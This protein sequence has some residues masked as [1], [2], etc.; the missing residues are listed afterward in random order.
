MTLLEKQ[1]ALTQTFIKE[2]GELTEDTHKIEDPI[3]K[4]GNIFKVDNAGEVLLVQVDPNVY[5]LIEI[6]NG[7]RHKNP[8]KLSSSAYDLPLSEI[9]KL[10]DGEVTFVRNKM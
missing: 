9:S 10:A 2:F 5:C 1:E 8:M 7:N 6:Y 4:C 3:Y